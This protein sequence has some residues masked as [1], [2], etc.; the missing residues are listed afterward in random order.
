MYIEFFST[1]EVGLQGKGKT[2]NTVE[3]PRLKWRYRKSG[4]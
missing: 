4:F 2:L 1:N 3:E